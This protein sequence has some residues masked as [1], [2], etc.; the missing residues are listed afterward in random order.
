MS[1]ERL[2]WFAINLDE[3]FNVSLLLGS[4]LP[5]LIAAAIVQRKRRSR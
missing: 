4:F 5:L 3:V 1:G 2:A